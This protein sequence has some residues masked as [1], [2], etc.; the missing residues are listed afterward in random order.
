MTLPLFNINKHVKEECHHKP[1]HLLLSVGENTTFENFATIFGLYISEATGLFKQ[2]HDVN[3]TMS[4]K[5]YKDGKGWVVGDVLGEEIYL[6]NSTNTDTVPEYG[7]MMMKSGKWRVVPSIRVRVVDISNALCGNIKLSATGAARIQ[8]HSMGQFQ[9]TGQFSAGRQVFINQRTGEY[10][11]VCPDYNGWEVNPRL[12]DAGVGEVT[13][14]YDHGL[15]PAMRRTAV[16]TR[17]SRGRLMPWKYWDNDGM[18]YRDGNM[19]IKAEC[20]VHSH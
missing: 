11:F 2:L 15:C 7:W 10:L 14:L 18:C 16:N 13:S 4:C 17:Y 12:D 20:S 19:N 6:W 5:L 9:P 3:T 8:S 1:V